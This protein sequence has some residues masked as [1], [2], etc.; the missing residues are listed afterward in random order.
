[1]GRDKSWERREKGK[2]AW[3]PPSRGGCTSASSSLP[4][5]HGTWRMLIR[6]SNPRRHNVTGEPAAGIVSAFGEQFANGRVLRGLLEN[7]LNL[8]YK[9]RKI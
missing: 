2:T 7:D 8:N 3:Q 4:P 6:E 1:M 5:K 9:H